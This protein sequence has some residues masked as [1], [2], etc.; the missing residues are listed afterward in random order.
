VIGWRS[1]SVATNLG[2]DNFSLPF[3]LIITKYTTEFSW[4]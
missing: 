3:F 1:F 2:Y 4:F